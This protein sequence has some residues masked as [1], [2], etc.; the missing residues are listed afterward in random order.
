VAVPGVAAV[1]DV[2]PGGR[3]LLQPAA[4]ECVLTAIAGQDGEESTVARRNRPQSL[5]AA[6]FAIGHIQ[7]VR[8]AG[9][10]AENL[11]GRHV[12]V[13]VCGVAI[14]CLKVHGDSPVGAHGEHEQ[15]LLEV[16][17]VI[18]VVAVAYAQGLLAVQ[19]TTAG[20]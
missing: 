5:G 4:E 11:P 12:R 18:L 16:G 2:F 7:E 15:Q 19:A 8:P 3:V 20:Q 6:Q 17:S 14:K 13:D 9:Q 10:R 1:R